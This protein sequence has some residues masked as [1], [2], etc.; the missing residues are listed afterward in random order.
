MNKHKQVEA[1]CHM[2]YKCEK[3]RREITVWN[4]RDA[5]TPFSINCREA[6]CNGTMI[7]ISWHF[8]RYDPNYKPKAGD[9]IFINLTEKA[10]RKA[11]G[12]IVKNNWDKG[13]CPMI[14]KYPNK[15][16]VIDQLTKSIYTPGSNAPDIIRVGN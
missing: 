1:F 14:E 7:H 4:S 5:V 12:R 15:K 13:L 3:C 6:G 8:D 10:A 2:L 16:A 11:A 9:Y